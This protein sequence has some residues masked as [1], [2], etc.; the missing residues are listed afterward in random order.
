M[1]SCVVGEGRLFGLAPREW[2]VLLG[3]SVLC[4]LLTLI[5]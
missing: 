4:S 5:F 2:S 1:I 3:S